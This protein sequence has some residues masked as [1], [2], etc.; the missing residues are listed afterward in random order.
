MSYVDIYKLTYIGVL[1][2]EFPAIYRWSVDENVTP[3]N[4]MLYC[5]TLVTLAANLAG[6][7]LHVRGNPYAI[8][9]ERVLSLGRMLIPIMASTV[10]LAG[11]VFYSPIFFVLWAQVFEIAQVSLPALWAC[12]GLLLGLEIAYCKKIGECT[13]HP[14]Q[15]GDLFH[16][17]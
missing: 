12:C 11:L 13:H 7:F 4:T 14:K 3:D 1:L 6:W 8:L 17:V 2:L 5:I 10:F 9:V 15:R 16:P